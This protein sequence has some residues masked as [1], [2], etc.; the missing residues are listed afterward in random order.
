[1]RRPG[2]RQRHDAQGCGP[3]AAP[4]VSPTAGLPSYCVFVRCGGCR[5]F[6]AGRRCLWVRLAVQFNH[7]EELRVWGS[8]R[9]A[10]A[11]RVQP[12]PR[13]RMGKQGLREVTGPRCKRGSPPSC[14]HRR[15]RTPCR[16]EAVSAGAAATG[17][18][19]ASPPPL[20]PQQHQ[21]QQYQQQEP[22]LLPPTAPSA[23]EAVREARASVLVQ[24]DQPARAARAARQIA[25]R[26][27][28]RSAA[29][30]RR[31]PSSQL[32]DRLR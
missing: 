29:P 27:S 14:A 32:L 16:C 13:L 8:V 7:Q 11:S 25:R 3:D 24:R 15:C 21:Q 5:G 19:A 30:R 4:A 10:R 2:P 23:A 12:P 9:D 26:R 20:Q 17:L 28:R 1:M 31:G 18:L 22:G 6:Q